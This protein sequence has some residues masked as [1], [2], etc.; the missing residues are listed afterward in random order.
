MERDA[1]M[2]PSPS[3][4]RSR[5]QLPAHVRRRRRTLPGLAVFAFAAGLG[6][7][8]YPQPINESCMWRGTA[9]FCEGHCEPGELTRASSSDGS[10]APDFAGFGAP[11][12][13]GVKA[14]CCKPLFPDETGGSRSPPS[15]GGGVPVGPQTIP[16]PPLQGRELEKGPIVAPPGPVG[17][18]SVNKGPI[19]AKPGDSTPPPGQTSASFEG[20][21][22]AVADNVNYNMLFSQTGTAV[23]GDF[24]GADGSHGQ[25]SGAL[26]GKVLRFTWTQ[27]DGAK[28]SGKFTLSGDGQS[29]AGS[30]NFGTNPDVVQGMW[31]GTRR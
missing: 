7:A 1:E 29:F 19:I 5:A 31:N 8:A 11:C 26:D 16:I 23:I 21:W 3:L 24:V 17:E 13:S 10:N 30:Y 6:G 2:M 18:T 22:K 9:P 25:L 15:S 27:L 28:G 12:W 4:P 14:Y 20:A